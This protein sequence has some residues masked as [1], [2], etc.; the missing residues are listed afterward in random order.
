MANQN[1][2]YRFAKSDMTKEKFE[3]GVYIE[4]YSAINAP[5]EIDNNITLSE[6]VVETDH[7]VKQETHYNLHYSMEVGYDREEQYVVQEKKYDTTLKKDVVRNVVKTRKVTDWRPHSGSESN[8]SGMDAYGLRRRVNMTD[9]GER[10]NDVYRRYSSGLIECGTQSVVK[11]FKEERLPTEEEKTMCVPL[12]EEEHLRYASIGANDEIFEIKLRPTFPGDQQR[13]FRTTKWEATDMN[14]TV[15]V[16]DRYKLA[17][18]C[19]GE[20]CFAG[21]YTTSETPTIYCSKVYKDE[22]IAEIDAKEQN[23]LENDPEYQKWIKICKYGLIGDVALF[24]LS[25]VLMNSSLILGILLLVVSIAGFVLGGKL[26]KKMN[27]TKD[28]IKSIYKE[29]RESHWTKLQNKKIQLLNDRFIK[30]GINP[31]TEEELKRFDLENKHILNA[32]YKDSQA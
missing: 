27:A 21:Q 6:T 26:G 13:K 11:N 32:H 8:V 17:F 5:E 31:L 9:I 3:R 22:V 16:V 24:I 25:L 2:T 10:E 14:A 29:Q 28:S 23:H 1:T 7:I 20:K 15:Y 4:I 19:D 18:D 30:M 12:S